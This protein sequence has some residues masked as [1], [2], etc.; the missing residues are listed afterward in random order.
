M[1]LVEQR[2]V[3][4]M[5]AAGIPPMLIYAFEKTGELVTETNQHMI[6]NADL[7]EFN[8]AVDEWYELFGNPEE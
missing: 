3:E 5:K 4:G 8:A 2:A 7:A 1:E 6:P